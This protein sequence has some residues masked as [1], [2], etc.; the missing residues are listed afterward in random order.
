M[1][2]QDPAELEGLSRQHYSTSIDLQGPHAASVAEEWFEFQNRVSV[3]GNQ[4]MTYLLAWFFAEEMDEKIFEM[5]PE[6]F[7]EY[8]A[9]IYREIYEPDLDEKAERAVSSM[10]EEEK[11]ELVEAHF[12]EDG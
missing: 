2:P 12:E 11:E 3:P 1:N 6:D 5:D 9:K 7:R 8:P 4:A 10:S